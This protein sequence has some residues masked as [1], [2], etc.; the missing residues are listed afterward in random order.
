MGL[1]TL[2]SLLIGFIGFAAVSFAEPTEVDVPF[3]SSPLVD[4]V[5]LLS[6][7][8]SSRVRGLLGVVNRS[9]KIQMAILIADSLQGF[10]IESYSIAV[11]E[12]WKLG[13]KDKDNGL[14]LVL[15]PKER[16]IRIEVGYGL[17]GVITDAKS[18]QFID[19]QMLPYFKA[20]RFG[21]G[22]LVGIES[23][24]KELKLS[25]TVPVERRL[26]PRDKR[27]TLPTYLFMLLFFFLFI[28]SF[29]GGRRGGRFGGGRRYMGYG[30]G[31]IG[32]GFGGGRGFGGG[33]FGGGGG[34]GFGGGG[35]SGGW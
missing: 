15:A 10:E 1:F 21:D 19:N 25:L 29:F 18:R 9:D 16:K 12:K 24:A 30:G 31:G 4:Q 2:H 35:A 34:G 6:S 17:E 23:I 27:R 32:G 3:F 22:L 33:G 26:Q 13:K 28:S 7:E 20:N 14:L 8:E 11:V 5:N